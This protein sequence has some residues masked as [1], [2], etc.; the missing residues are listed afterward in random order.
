M[1]ETRALRYAYP[2]GPVLSFHDVGVPQG[3]TMLL[4]GNSGAGKSTWLALAAGLLTPSAGEVVIA[5]QPL[6]KLSRAARDA[7]R[8]RSIGF[9]PQKLHLSDALTVERNLSLAFY[10]AGV[11]EDGAA[12]ARALDQLGVGD[13]ANRRPSQLSGGQAQRVALARSILMAPKVILADEPTASLDDESA[14]TGLKLLED[15][16]RRCNATLVIATHDRRVHEAM[17]TATVYQLG[18]AVADAQG[19]PS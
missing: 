5:G 15:C 2:S 3:G 6:S 12:V 1:I 14:R 7:W 19:A 13:L 17:P 4:R 18:A 9:L 16:A 11:R 8:A 10:A